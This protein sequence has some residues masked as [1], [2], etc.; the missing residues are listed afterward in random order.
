MRRHETGFLYV[1]LR[2][3]ADGNMI[4]EKVSALSH[5]RVA[6]DRE[7]EEAARCLLDD[8]EALGLFE[9]LSPP[10]HHLES[11]V[12]V[13]RAWWE[14]HYA[15]N[16]GDVDYSGF[17]VD[18]VEHATPRPDL[19]GAWSRGLALMGLMGLGSRVRT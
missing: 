18:Q 8:H 14:T 17:I 19:S 3:N 1:R 5:P 9:D 15:G 2:R 12:V 16:E 7:E 11:L 13:G 10:I 6:R 4:V